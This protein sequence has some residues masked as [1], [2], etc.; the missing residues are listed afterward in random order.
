MTDMEESLDAMLENLRELYGS[1]PFA[2][3][4][5]EEAEEEELTE[6][7]LAELAGELSMYFTP[8]MK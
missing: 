3:A 4:L 2:Q 7:L 5:I 6:E 1:D 8:D